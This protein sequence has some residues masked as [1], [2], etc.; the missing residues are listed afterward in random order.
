MA[1]KEFLV[2][3][4]GITGLTVARELLEKGEKVTVIEKSN[5]VGGLMFSPKHIEHL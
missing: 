5:N 4:A 3:G 1:L 2:L